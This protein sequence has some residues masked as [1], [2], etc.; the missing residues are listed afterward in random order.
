MS[1]TEKNP[2][3]GPRYYEPERN[4]EFIERGKNKDGTPRLVRNPEYIAF[5]GVPNRDITEDEFAAMPLHIQRQID[6]SP[7]HRKTKPRP[8]SPAKADTKPAEPAKE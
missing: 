1:D 4:P 2:D 5:M 7:V 3:I 6:A 8:A